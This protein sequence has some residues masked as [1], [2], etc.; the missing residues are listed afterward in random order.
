MIDPGGRGGFLKLL[1]GSR[2][3]VVMG[4]RKQKEG[5]VFPADTPAVTFR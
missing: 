3:C 5:A 2:R 4:F 1:N